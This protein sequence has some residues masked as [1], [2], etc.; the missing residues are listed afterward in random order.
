MNKIKRRI[1]ALLL[2]VFAV[3]LIGGNSVRAAGGSSSMGVSASSVNIGDTV[4]VTL[5]VT[6][7]VY[8]SF[9]MAVSYSSDILEY[10][11]SN[12]GGDCNGGGGALAVLSEVEAGS[13]YSINISFRAI[14]PGSASISASAVEAIAMETAEGISISGSSTSVTVNNAA[15]NPGGGT[16]TPGGGTEPPAG[17]GNSGGGGSTPGGEDQPQEPRKSGDN[18]L[19]SLTISPGSLSPSFKPS[20]TKYTAKVGADVTSVA[21]DAQVSNSKAT[22]ESVTGNTNLEM[23]DNQIKIVV[24]A[25]NGTLATYIITV[26]RGGAVEPEEPEDETEEPI[27]T[28][29]DGPITID[30]VSY[31]VS[32]TFPD[33]ELPEEFTKTTVIYGDKEVEAYSF[34][35]KNLALLYLTRATEEG[36]D[37]GTE[38]E[39]T[40]SGGFFFYDAAGGQFFHYINVIVGDTYVL[41]LPANFAEAA[42]PDGY[43]ETVVTIHGLSVKG[44]Q[45]TASDTSQESGEFYLVYGVNKD[46]TA[47]W[48]QYDTVEASLQRYHETA[49]VTPEQVPQQEDTSAYD[50]AYAE[51]DSRYKE[52]KSKARLTMAVLIFL[53]AV[54]VIVIVNILIFTIKGK[55]SSK[56]KGKKENIDYIDFDDLD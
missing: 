50:E 24:K 36:E 45:Q 54:A 21:V 1:A 55:G 41:A 51:L 42:V 7:D 20:T 47:G 13:N 43:Q 26:N 19:K 23:G 39:E 40:E 32:E 10:T 22:V 3:T 46:G 5:N 52:E 28:P 29:T 17:G 4:N 27:E 8:A 49:Y 56:R 12:K 25:E 18:S 2:A 33:N 31:E 11:G 30:G 38:D 35:Y 16:E 6:A 48:Y 53:L 14:A 15:N 44:Y 34:P 37:G 9:R